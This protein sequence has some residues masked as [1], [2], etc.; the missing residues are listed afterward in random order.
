MVTATEIGSE[1]TA[2]VVGKKSMGAGKGIMTV[3]GTMIHESNEGTSLETCIGSWWVSRSSSFSYFC[4][5]G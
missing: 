5:Q 1:G 2:A 4:R 3:M